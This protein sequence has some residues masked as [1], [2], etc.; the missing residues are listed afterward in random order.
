MASFWD[1]LV[2]SI[3]NLP[4][5]PLSPEPAAALDSSPGPGATPLAI[6]SAGNGNADAVLGDSL[7]SIPSN[8]SDGI[9]SV[10]ASIG[11]FLPSSWTVLEWAA[12]LIVVLILIAYI[13]REVAG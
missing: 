11:G 5:D 7:A 3:G 1:S 9:S 13:A 12:I 10:A 2:N 4:A 8:V 6:Q